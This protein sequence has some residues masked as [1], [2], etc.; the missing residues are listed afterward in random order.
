[1]SD[2][3][4]AFYSTRKPQLILRSRDHKWT[5]LQMLH[6]NDVIRGCLFYGYCVILGH[7]L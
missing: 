2:L 6:D 1:M 3:N 7:V 5:Y 4:R